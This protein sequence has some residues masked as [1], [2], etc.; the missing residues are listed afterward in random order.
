MTVFCDSLAP[1]EESKLKKLSKKLNPPGKRKEKQNNSISKETDPFSMKA[2]RLHKQIAAFFNQSI[3]AYE[4]MA[5]DESKKGLSPVKQVSSSADWKNL[6]FTQPILFLSQECQSIDSSYFAVPLLITPESSIP[7]DVSNILSHFTFKA[8]SPFQLPLPDKS[9]TKNHLYQSKDSKQGKILVRILR[10]IL[11][12]LLASQSSGN[13]MKMN[14]E[15]KL[16]E[17]KISLLREFHDLSFLFYLQKLIFPSSS[18]TNAM[19]PLFKKF[20]EE[21]VSIKEEDWNNLYEILFPSLIHKKKS[22]TNKSDGK[23]GKLRNVSKEILLQF[24]LFLS[25][26]PKEKIIY[27]GEKPA[28]KTHNDDEDEDEDDEL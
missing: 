24:Q 26:L 6:T 9:Q 2:Y 27:D 14:E 28:S 10:T 5:D 7:P 21:F 13:A 3:L 22:K 4:S 17:E 23:V 15:S 20:L 1:N 8:L 18:K 25:S 16:Q 19:N 12:K 11:T